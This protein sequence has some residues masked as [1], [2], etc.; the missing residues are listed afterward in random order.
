MWVGESER[1]CGNFCH[2][3]EK[4]RRGLHAFLFIDEA[5]SILGR[6]RITSFN[7]LSTL[8]PTFCWRWTNDSLNDVVI[9]L[10]SNRATDLIDPVILRPGQSIEKLA[11]QIKTCAKFTASISRMIFLTTQSCKEADGLEHRLST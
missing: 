9:I 5:E 3:S 7:I 2:G 4:T 8:V 6:P 11:G 1:W 10:A